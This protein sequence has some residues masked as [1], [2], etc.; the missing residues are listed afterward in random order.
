MKFFP[1]MRPSFTIGMPTDSCLWLSSVESKRKNRDS[2]SLTLKASREIK[3][4][5]R[6][7]EFIDPDYVCAT[8]F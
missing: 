4:Q 3:K 1:L 5:E 6:K 7:H 2:W 8:R